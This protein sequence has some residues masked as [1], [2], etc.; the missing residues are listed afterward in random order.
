M[1]SR[2]KEVLTGQAC[3][4]LILN[5]PFSNLLPFYRKDSSAQYIFVVVMGSRKLGNLCFS[6]QGLF[7]FPS[8]A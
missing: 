7:W 8:V 3:Y 4:L 2:C 5:L 6:L 1:N